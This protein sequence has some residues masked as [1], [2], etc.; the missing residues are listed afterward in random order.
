MSEGEATLIG[1]LERIVFS[2]PEDG[3]LIGSFLVCLFVEH[4]V[5]VAIEDAIR[6]VKIF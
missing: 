5:F 6:G 2:N 1:T 3:F 4:A